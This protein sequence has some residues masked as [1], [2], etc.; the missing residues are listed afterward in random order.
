MRKITCKRIGRTIPG[1]KPH[2]TFE[3]LPAIHWAYSQLW[4]K[5]EVG[6]GGIEKRGPSADLEFPQPLSPVVEHLPLAGQSV[7][8]E[9]CSE[10]TQSLKIN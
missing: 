2:D 5:G 1:R 7:K 8:S 9:F 10:N 6:T 4:G 3:G